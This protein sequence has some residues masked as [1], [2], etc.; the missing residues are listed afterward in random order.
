LNSGSDLLK[1]ADRHVGE[2]YR[3]VLVPKNNSRW[4]GPWD[5]AEFASWCVYQVSG[6]LYGCTDDTAPPAEA[7]AYTGAWQRDANDIGRRVLPE[8]AAAVPGALVLRYPPA[9]GA[10]GHIAICDGRGGTVEAH[11]QRRGVTRDRVSGRRWDTGVL[12]PGIEYQ[13]GAAPLPLAPPKTVIYRVTTPPMRGEK[14]KQIQ[15]ALRDAGFV[16]GRI[17]GEFGPLTQAAVVAFQQVRRLTPDG[18][19]GSRTARALG[20]TLP[21]A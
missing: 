9:P 11:S 8:Q 2:M 1:L 20:V 18:E 5:C 6:L 14:V 10:M 3:N 15:R 13:E 21:A 16:P 17:D 4:T 19:V 12:V 7:D